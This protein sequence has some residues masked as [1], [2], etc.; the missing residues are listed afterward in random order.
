MDKELQQIFNLLNIEQ[1]PNERNYW[2]IR[3]E[4]GKFYYDFLQNNY[5]AIGW[6]EFSD[7]DTFR[8]TEEKKLK[9]QIAKICKDE[10]KPGYIYNQIRRFM[11]DIKKGDMILIPSENSTQIAFGI[12]SD[13]FYV[14]DVNNSINNP[15]IPKCNFK[16]CIKVEW[17]SKIFKEKFDPYLRMLLFTHTTITDINNYKGYINRLLYSNYI[18][19]DM[20]HITFNVTTKKNINAIELVNFLN[21]VS[22]E[23]IDVFNQVTGSNFSKDTIDVKLNVQ[24][25]GPIEFIGYA[26]G[27]MLAISIVNAFLFGIKLDF[28][29]CNKVKFKID[30]E[31]LITYIFKFVQEKNSNNQALMKLQ[32][33]FEISKEKLKIQE[34]EKLLHSPQIIEENNNNSVNETDSNEDYIQISFDTEDNSN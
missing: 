24:S 32:H 13:S 15:K 20:I 16:K 22:K 27:G 17:K 12:V 9:E 21:L 6:D 23:S 7:I 29:I 3:T 14:R 4:S 8:N 11:F 10:K 5:V 30:N 18:L 19:D 31:G 25:P 1:I 2:L 26:A 28:E 34:S 33:D